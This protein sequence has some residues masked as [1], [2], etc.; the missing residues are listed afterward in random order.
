M[1][2]G[3]WSNLHSDNDFAWGLGVNYNF[4]PRTYAGIDYLRQYDKDGL[5]IDGWTINVG[6]RF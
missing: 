4:N 2:P 5:K 3:T 1:A 6:Y